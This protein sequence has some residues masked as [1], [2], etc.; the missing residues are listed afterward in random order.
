MPTSIRLPKDAEDRLNALVKETG[1][2]KAHYIREALLEYLDDLEDAA[3][4]EKRLQDLPEGR[5]STH[6]IEDIEQEFGLAD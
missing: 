6:S 3:I 2:S 4:A 5:S 1:R